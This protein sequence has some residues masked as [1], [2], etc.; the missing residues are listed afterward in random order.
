MKKILQLTVLLTCTFSFGQVISTLPAYD[1]FDYAID[2]KLIGDGALAPM[3]GQGGW[4]MVAA[5]STGLDDTKIIA[6][7][8]WSYPGLPAYGGNALWFTGAGSDPEFLFTSQTTGTIYASFIFRVEDNVAT[9]AG[10]VRHFFSF[11][12]TGAIGDASSVMYKEV[13]DGTYN[14]GLSKSSSQTEGVWDPGVFT[15]GSE[16]FI[17]ISYSNIND[18]DPLMQKASLWIDPIISATEPTA[19]LTQNA[20]TTSITRTN[21]DR[22]KVNQGNNASTPIYNFDELRVATSWAQVVGGTLGV[23]KM[24]VSQFNAYPNPVTNGK[25]YISSANNREKKVAIFTVLGQ[26]VLDTKTSNNSEINVSQL[27]KGAYLLS[28]TEDGKSE[29]KKLIIQ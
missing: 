27:A 12:G 10:S 19:T 14:I 22:I 16:H 13:A 23:A 5:H 1:G 4:S 8:G 24:D 9:T 20:P 21:L 6:S 25:L 7:P 18:P 3:I 29:F 26:K 11:S 15:V 28:V 2:S 17:V